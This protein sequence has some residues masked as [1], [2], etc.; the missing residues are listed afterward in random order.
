MAKLMHTAAL[1]GNKQHPDTY[2]SMLCLLAKYLPA[3]QVSAL[4]CSRWGKG[5]SVL[6][7]LLLVGNLNGETSLGLAPTPC[8][9]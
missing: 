3:A 5:G 2:S 6:I 1:L 7:E 8:M 9:A 4:I